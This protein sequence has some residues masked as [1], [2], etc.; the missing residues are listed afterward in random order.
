MKGNDR[1]E[2]K[3]R[4][5]DEQKDWALD[6]WSCQSVKPWCCFRGTHLALTDLATRAEI[7]AEQC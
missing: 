2:E 4:K 6:K 5:S 3:E 7:G 1:L